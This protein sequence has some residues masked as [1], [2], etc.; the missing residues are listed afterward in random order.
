MTIEMKPV[1]FVRNSRSTPEDDYW[2]G[3]VSEIV[4]ADGIPDEALDGIDAFSHLEVVYCFNQVTATEF[5]FARHPRGNEAWPRVGIFAQRNK[6]RLNRI[7]LV[8]VELLERTGRTLRVRRL[9]AIDGTPVLDIK[10]VFR[11]FG[12][13]SEVKQPQWVDELLNDYWK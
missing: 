1:A 3:I 12:P 13:E 11:Q 7:G 9:D 4:L 6:D 2:G 10:P 5:P 8:T